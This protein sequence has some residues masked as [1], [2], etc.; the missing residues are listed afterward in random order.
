MASTLKEKAIKGISWN[1]LERFGVQ[2]TT[3][4]LG[5]ILA[6][7]LS[8]K[9]FGLIAMITVFFT[10]AEVFIRSGFGEA[11][12]QKKA[13]TSLDAST[14]FYTNLTISG[15][16][17]LCL[18]FCAPVISRFYEQPA[19]TK[20]TRV[21]GTI[22]I[23]Y[24]FNIVQ[25]A[26]IKRELDFKRKTKITI[27]ATL[28]SGIIGILSAYRGLGVW[29]LVLKN[30]S[31]ACILTIGLWNNSEWKPKLQFSKESFL[32]MFS[33]GA[34]ILSANIVRTIFE[35]IYRLTIGKLFSAVE[36]GFYTNAKSFQ[37]MA[38]NHLIQAITF[39]AF[40]VFAQLQDEKTRLQQAMRKFLTHTM[41]FVM[42]MMITLA[43]IAKPFVNLLLTEKW[44]PMI[45]YLQLLCIV[46]LLYP[47]QLVNLQVLLAQGKSNLNFILNLIKNSLRIINI[48]I[49]H[50][51]GVLY[52]IIGEVIISFIN[53]IINTYYTKKL[54]NYG[55]FNQMKDISEI[56]AGAIIVGILSYSFTILYE[57]Q[58]LLL[59]STIF[60]SCCIYIGIQYMIN[61]QLFIEVISLNKLFR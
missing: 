52:I 41:L 11:Y 60:L 46:G 31:G 13:V 57:S 50:K 44:A 5:I 45:P 2:G 49:M 39:V 56:L 55:L 23:F 37:L 35:N 28:L 24:A 9:D 58:W 4:I 16:L 18:W 59:I 32:A 17:Y 10:I 26:Q 38:S 12:V 48:I 42:P 30:L 6:R 53:L 61:R 29:S 34:W 27:T 8:P 33:F 51:Y 14:I 22:I 47:I 21:M 43:A 1:L 25:Q 15:L 54:I 20:L 19:L 36:L 40:P 7:L 3:V